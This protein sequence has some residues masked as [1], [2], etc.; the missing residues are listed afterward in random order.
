[1]MH[2]TPINDIKNH[3]KCTTFDCSPRVIFKNSEM[4]IIH[5]AYD[6]RE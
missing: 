4:I 1:M 3:V 6:G 5:N 2:V